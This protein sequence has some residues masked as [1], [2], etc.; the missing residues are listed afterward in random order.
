MNKHTGLSSSSPAGRVRGSSDAW[1]LAGLWEKAL[2][3][4]SLSPSETVTGKQHKL[5]LGLKCS[6]CCGSRRKLCPGQAAVEVNLP[7]ST[8]LNS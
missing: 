5:G 3:I 7:P 6:R 2:I 1:N 4:F 8:G